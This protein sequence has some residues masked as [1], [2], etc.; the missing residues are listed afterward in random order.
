M[1]KED[2]KILLK[3]DQSVCIDLSQGT[4]SESEDIEIDF[5]EVFFEEDYP[6][7]LQEFG[8]KIYDAI[9]ALIEDAG[10]DNQEDLKPRF[11]ERG[12]NDVL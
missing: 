12:R 5:S 6:V 8:V 3:P 1:K 7:D 11:P 9:L 10:I 4:G 2:V